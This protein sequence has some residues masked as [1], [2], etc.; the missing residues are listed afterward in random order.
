MRRVVLAFL[1]ALVAAP[2]AHAASPLLGIK[3][4]APRFQGL[5]NQQ[6]QVQHVIVAWGQGL[7]FGSKFPDLIAE[8]KLR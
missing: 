2:A 7:S 6:S 5:T 8:F 4:D 3:G 1:L